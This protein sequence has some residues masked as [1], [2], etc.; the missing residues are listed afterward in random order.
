MPL[1]V[2]IDQL[3]HDVGSTAALRR[4]EVGKGLPRFLSHGRAGDMREFPARRTP[5]RTFFDFFFIGH[6]NTLHIRF[7]GIYLWLS[8]LKRKEKE[9]T[10]IH[11]DRAI[12]KARAKGGFAGDDAALPLW[13]MSKR[14]LIEAAMRLGGMTT[15][16]PADPAECASAVI[17][18]IETL[19]GNGIL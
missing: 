1:N 12:K 5:D 8:K 10:S 17:Q 13:E 15:E 3:A 14:E 2:P 16:D 6:K 7:D 9:M 18:E 4:G 19:K 11:V